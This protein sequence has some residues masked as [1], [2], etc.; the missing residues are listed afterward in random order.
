MWNFLRRGV[1]PEVGASLLSTDEPPKYEIA[2]TEAYIRAKRAALAFS[3]LLA[4]SSFAGKT[5]TL[6]GFTMD[7]TV[8]KVLLGAAAFYHVGLFLVEY[9]G[10]RRRHTA[11]TI[12]EPTRDFDTRL[13]TIQNIILDQKREIE[14]AAGALKDA[15]NFSDRP[16]LPN[17]AHEISTSAFVRSIDQL[18]IMLKDNDDLAPSHV[19]QHKIQVSHQLDEITRLRDETSDFISKSLQNQERQLE[20]RLTEQSGHIT[21]AAETVG[22]SA[23]SIEALRQ[24]IKTLSKAIFSDQRLVVQWFDRA[25]VVITFLTSIG[26]AI[27]SSHM[28]GRCSALWQTLCFPSA[29]EKAP[30]ATIALPA[31]SALPPA[32]Q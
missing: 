5:A 4:V 24:D 13:E 32:V 16:V 22:N 3:S 31:A 17:L 18:H 9:R 11:L 19:Q 6:S 26:L 14:R 15:A 7:V 8:L 12:A 30:K 20:N 1:T 23:A 27:A 29:E 25:T 10:M 2:L 28:A 21:R